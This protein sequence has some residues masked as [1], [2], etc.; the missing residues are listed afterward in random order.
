MLHRD[1]K[2]YSTGEIQAGDVVQLRCGDGSLARHKCPVCKLF[3]KEGDR[4]CNH[5]AT[6]YDKVVD[7]YIIHHIPE[8]RQRDG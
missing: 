3:M 4:E 2:E 6:R 5:C 8:G 1:W 7:G